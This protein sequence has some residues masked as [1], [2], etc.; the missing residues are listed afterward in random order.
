MTN[1][2]IFSYVLFP[3][4]GSKY[5][6]IV[7]FS[8]Q[9]RITLNSLNLK[10][11]NKKKLD[12]FEKI[13]LMGLYVLKT[14]E[15]DF[16]SY[17]QISDETFKSLAEISGNQ[18]AGGFIIEKFDPLNSTPFSDFQYSFVE[19]YKNQNIMFGFKMDGDEFKTELL[20]LVG[21]NKLMLD[22]Y[23]SSIDSKTGHL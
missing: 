14:D 19:F 1:H 20:T 4:K 3:I 11:I 8:D 9:L 22:S 10:L 6:L 21:F 5:V 7:P 18:K 16:N 17:F 15:V 2:P 23:Q 13:E 12:S